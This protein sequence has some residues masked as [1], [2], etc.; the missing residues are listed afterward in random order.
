MPEQPRPP[1]PVLIRGAR[2][3]EFDRIGALRV[4][5]YRADGFLS[6]GAQYADTL[7]ILGMDGT[8]EILAA[9]DGGDIIGTVTL[10]QGGGGNNRLIAGGDTV[11]GAD[12]P[13]LLFGSTSQDDSFY[14]AADG[15]RV[16]GQAL[17]FGAAGNNVLDA[18]GTTQGVILY[19]GAGN[20]TIYGGAGNDLIAGG[21][22]SNVIHAGQGDN[23][24]FGNA[25][26]NIDLSAPIDLSR[27]AQADSRSL[28]SLTLVLTP[29]EAG[30]RV[31]GGAADGL[32]AAGGGNTITAG[33]GNNIIFANYGQIVTVAPVNYLR[34]RSD[35][36]DP[37]PANGATVRYLSGDGLVAIENFNLPAGGVNVITVGNGRNVILG[38]MG[39]DVIRAEGPNGYN[40]IAGDGGA[41]WFNGQGHIET[42]GSIYPSVGG[43]DTIYNNG[44]GV[45]LGGQGN[46]TLQSGINGTIMFGDNG[47]VTFVNGHPSLIEARDIDYGGDDILLAG[48]AGNF[49]IGGPGDDQFLGNL[50]KDVMVGDYAAIYLD[51]QTDHIITEVRFGLGG[52]HPDL[53]TEVMED[54]YLWPAALDRTTRAVFHLDLSHDRETQVS[55]GTE[56]AIDLLNGGSTNLIWFARSGDEVSLKPDAVTGESGGQDAAPQSV[57]QGEPETDQAPQQDAAPNPV[58]SR[59]SVLHEEPAT[60]LLE[61]AAPEE[62]AAPR[63]PAM[64]AAAQADSPANPDSS[65]ASLAAGVG[66]LGLAGALGSARP[67][68]FNSQN[69]QWESKA[70]RKN[71]LRV[72]RKEAAPQQ[73]EV[74][75]EEVFL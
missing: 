35:F 47:R 17:A 62:L 36:I 4:A 5:A 54:I 64:P 26:M 40:L 71:G 44:A 20:D 61:P 9:L 12:R 14:T 66:L 19:G 10:V 7:R 32:R 60:S 57:R 2:P 72:T 59:E 31:V 8:G 3:E 42:F 48:T 41:A 16:A 21:G 46:D 33:D 39:D 45:M 55:M 43:N 68:V 22:G 38:G 69:S 11:G 75:T 28:A 24:V 51:P 65:R 27:A 50:A 56:M 15:H 63:K 67:V 70:R 6:E 30:A 53:I 52:N 23:I 49:M 1:A 29:E 25:G 13:L 74:I 34:S 58:Q 37:A 73:R 18:R